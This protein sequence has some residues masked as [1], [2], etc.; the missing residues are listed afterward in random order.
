MKPFTITAWFGTEGLTKKV[1]GPVSKDAVHPRA[2]G[3]HAGVAPGLASNCLTNG[4]LE[5]AGRKARQKRNT[6]GLVKGQHFNTRSPAG[7][8]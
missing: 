4:G 1:A 7:C 2:C 3:E 8:V 5:V 6:F